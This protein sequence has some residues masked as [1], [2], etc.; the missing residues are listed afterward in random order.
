MQYVEITDRRA[1]VAAGVTRIAGTATA[2]D[3][4]DAPYVLVGTLDELVAEIADHHQRWGISSYVVRTD[5][6]DSVARVI[7][8]LR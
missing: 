5:A 6:I 4:L 2:A 1:E 8:R 7:E 3:V